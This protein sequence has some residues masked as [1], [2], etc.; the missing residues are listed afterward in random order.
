MVTSKE[1]DYMYS[2][3]ASDARARINLGIRR[4]LA[5]LLENNTE[6]IRLMNSLLTRSDCIPKSSEASY[7]RTLVG[8]VLPLF[9]GGGKPTAPCMTCTSGGLFNVRSEARA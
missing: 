3:Y 6:R 5:P 7:A 9:R 1:R 2:M 4:R 8:Q